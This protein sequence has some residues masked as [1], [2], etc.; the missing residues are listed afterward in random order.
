MENQMDNNTNI[1]S[2]QP[3]PGAPVETF[4]PSDNVLSA[5]ENRSMEEY[6]IAQGILTR[7]QIDAMKA[8]EATAAAARHA[9]K[10]SSGAPSEKLGIARSIEAMGAQNE[11]GDEGGISAEDLTVINRDHPPA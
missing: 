2:L 3:A 4:D 8:R 6:A 10:P 11:P 9:P 7:E 1:P 5:A